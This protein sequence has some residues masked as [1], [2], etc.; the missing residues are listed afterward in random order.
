MAEKTVDICTE[1]YSKYI[2]QPIKTVVELGARDCKESV[3]FSELLPNARI[4]AFECNPNTLELCRANIHDHVNI[5]LIEKAVTDKNSKIK[6][7]TINPQKTTT[8][9]EDGNPGASSV[10]RASGKYPIEQYVQD[11]IEV[12]S[13]TLEKF[14]HEN[15]IEDVDLL[16]MDIQGAELMLLKGVVKE[17]NT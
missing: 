15:N 3:R 1:E 8:T 4:F 16:W 13:I 6:F 9:W 2:L 17:S 11:E 14:L 7:Y 10:F 12:D 5:S